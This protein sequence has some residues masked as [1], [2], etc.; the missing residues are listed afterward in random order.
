MFS[1]DGAY[2]VIVYVYFKQWMS[3]FQQE[4]RI[5]IHFLVAED[6]SKAEIHRRLLAIFNSETL[7]RG[8]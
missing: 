1:G 5:V 4:Q 7:S 3:T 8:G 2:D 6:V